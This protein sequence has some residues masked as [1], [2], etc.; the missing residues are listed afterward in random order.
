MS[1]SA[2]LVCRCKPRCADQTVSASVSLV[3][4][5]KEKAQP[6]TALCLPR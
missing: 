3:S 5:N 4:A 2:E 1:A 6:L